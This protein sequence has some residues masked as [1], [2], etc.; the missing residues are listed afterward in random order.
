MP[1][2]TLAL[3]ISV[4]WLLLRGDGSPGNFFVG[5]LLAVILIYFLRRTYQQERAFRRAGDIVNFFIPR[6][7]TC[8]H[9]FSTYRKKK[10]NSRILIRRATI[11]GT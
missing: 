2:A 6:T 10:N 4:I 8:M 3:S 5:L 11:V 7:K 9:V 1:L